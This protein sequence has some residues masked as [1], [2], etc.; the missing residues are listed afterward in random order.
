MIDVNGSNCICN[1]TTTNPYQSKHLFVAS[2][3]SLSGYEKPF[4][5]LMKSS[6]SPIL[7][8]FWMTKYDAKF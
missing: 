5:T 6:L 4:I 3:E 7:D 1:L 2:L 8:S